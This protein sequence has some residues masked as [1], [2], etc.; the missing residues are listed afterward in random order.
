MNLLD[1]LLVGRIWKSDVIMLILFW[2]LEFWVRRNAPNAFTTEI[3][4]ERLNISLEQ[5][6]LQ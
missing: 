2:W 6:L 1:V 4:D 5:L 3:K